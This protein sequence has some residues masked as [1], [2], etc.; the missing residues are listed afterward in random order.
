MVGRTN[1]LKDKVG[2]LHSGGHNQESPTADWVRTAAIIAAVNRQVEL[3]SQW[4]LPEEFSAR[5]IDV[6]RVRTL[7][8]QI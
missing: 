8:S 5:D 7:S 1:K 6:V 2:T 4:R 3:E